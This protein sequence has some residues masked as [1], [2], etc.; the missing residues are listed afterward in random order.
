MAK[1]EMS[2]LVMR[3]HNLDQMTEIRLGKD[4]IEVSIMYV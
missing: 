2:Y 4:K 3:L 1:S